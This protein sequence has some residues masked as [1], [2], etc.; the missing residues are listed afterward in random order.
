MPVMRLVPY[1][2]GQYAIYRMTYRGDGGWSRWSLDR[3]PLD[4]LVSTYLPEIG[5]SEFFELY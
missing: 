4:R 2:G 3:G 1:E 5:T